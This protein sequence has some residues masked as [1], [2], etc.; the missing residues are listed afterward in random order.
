M[1]EQ[2][3][4][5]ENLL[6][7]VLAKGPPLDSD[8]SN[9]EVIDKALAVLKGQLQLKDVRGITDQE[10]EAA[11]ANGYAMFRA[12]NYEKAE[13]MFSFLAT[14][15]TMEKKYWTALGAT[16]FNQ[17]K[18]DD[19]INAYSQAVMIDV[20]DPALLIKLAQCHLGRGDKETAAGALEAAQEIASGK[21]E[22]AKH[23]GRI[24]AMLD[25][26]RGTA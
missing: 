10:M 18:F 6:R 23:L 13:A 7:Q 25:L 26:L 1:L 8:L 9:E 24:D 3:G 5:D 17:Q 11:Y 4:I 2:M 15:D 21:P 14:F 19:A 12:G 16:R 20:D 22:H